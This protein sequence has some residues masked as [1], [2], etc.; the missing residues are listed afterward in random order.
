MNH[1]LIVEFRRNLSVFATAMVVAVAASA[2]QGAHA[3]NLFVPGSTFQV[4]GTNSPDTFTDT[5]NLAAGT[6]SLD[7]GAVSL[8][9]SIV[10]TGLGSDTW[11]VFNYSVVSGAP[12][13]TSTY[14]EM[15]ENNLVAAVPINFIA[16]YG[17]YLTNG[18]AQ[19][20]TNGMFPGYSLMANPVPG[21]TGYGGGANGF[22]G[23]IAPGSPG[24]SFYAYT[25]YYPGFLANAGLDSA[26]INGWTQSLEFQA[27]SPTVPESSTWAMLL[28]GFAGLGFVG[29]REAGK[30]RPATA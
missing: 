22:V 25:N 23:P 3:T 19:T 20:P 27:Q 9:L 24:A 14:W 18:V 13:S 6:Y 30:A 5:V 26:T 16:A 1:E 10:P 7:G 29:Y 17:E 4:V 11:Y 12:L 21:M 8:N 15:Q 2:G 28:L